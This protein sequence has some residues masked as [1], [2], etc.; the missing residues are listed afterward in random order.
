MTNIQHLYHNTLPEEFVGTSSSSQVEKS[1][2]PSLVPSNRTSHRSV[3][4][5]AGL[6]DDWRTSP[7][8]GGHFP[9]FYG[10]RWQLKDFGRFISKIG[11]N[12]PI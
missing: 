8:T 7:G 12:D 6:E 1:S 2:V 11:G 10:F 5:M 9:V 4:A 3:G